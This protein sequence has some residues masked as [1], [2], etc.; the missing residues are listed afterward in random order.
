MAFIG[1]G[2]FSKYY[3]YIFILVVFRFLCDYLEG[4]NEKEYYKRSEDES[5]IDF[6][7]II[8]YHPLIRDFMYFFGAL[9]CGLVLYIIYI[10][11]E[12]DEKENKISLEK[13]ITIK[14]SM[15]GL[16]EEY[17]SL[18]IIIISFIYTAN[19]ALRTFLMS[20]KFD[21]GFWTL[22]ILFVIF[23][24][25]KILK[26]KIG[27]HQKVT[28]VILAFV[29]FTVQIITS[30]LPRTDHE[31]PD[32][33]C[34]DKYISDNNMYI[35]M[36]KKF[37]HYGWI[38]LILFL[39]IFDFIMRDYSWVKLKYIM[40]IKSIPVFKLM[41]LIGIIGCSL[42][43]I[44]FSIVS[45]TPCNVIEN[46]TKNPD[47]FTYGN[48]SQYVDFS[49]QVCGVIDY[50]EE[51]QKLT[52]YYDNFSIFISD[53]TN[54]SREGLEIFIIFFY[55]INNFVINFCHAMIL[56]HL[57]PNAMLV[58]INF[59]YLFSRLISYIKNGA[60][61]QFMLVE[62]FILLEFCEI[63]AI[64]AYMI[65]IELIELKFCKLDFHLRKNIEQRSMS[66]SQKDNI[67]AL[68]NELEQDDYKVYYVESSNK[69][70]DI[71]NTNTTEK[72][73]ELTSKELLD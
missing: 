4:F 16:K 24:S 65:Y 56:K 61:K 31:C 1:F 55:F 28:I 15:L 64:V 72:S 49:R 40:D 25:T 10:R 59:N 73:V 12:A 20:M 68:N 27:N 6:A 41:L 11:T 45:N 50:D 71:N 2:H 39:Y 63:M 44:C 8:A 53:Y 36:E 23:L 13:F 7:S 19:I 14:S 18:F 54:S 42:I 47:G 29:L 48:T 34:K 5:F 3:T 30:L 35:F 60:N 46:V 32:E 69:N 67:L 9:T 21:A 26:V 43:I 22:E 57:D 33:Q 51:T 62:Q 17:I 37:G 66:E 70:D 52:F 38:F 58:N